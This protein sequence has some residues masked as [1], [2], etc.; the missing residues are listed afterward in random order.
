GRRAAG[1][2]TRRVLPADPA[3][4]ALRTAGAGRFSDPGERAAR[5]RGRPGGGLRG[6]GCDDRE[7]RVRA[8]GRMTRDITPALGTRGQ[9]GRW[10]RAVEGAS[11]ALHHR[12]WR[13][14]YIFKSSDT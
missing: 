14:S 3:A 2:R 10:R 7:L 6:G 11:V 4:G 9:P 5:D 12:G 13:D 1:G 8:P